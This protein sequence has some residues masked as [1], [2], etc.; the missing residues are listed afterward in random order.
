[1]EVKVVPFREFAFI[2]YMYIVKV[3]SSVRKHTVDYSYLGYVGV[4]G[5]NGHDDRK[6][7]CSDV[8]LHDPC[9]IL[10]YIDSILL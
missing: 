1:M 3:R 6:V 8:V 7:A 10:I 4:C 5:V 2:I 9:F